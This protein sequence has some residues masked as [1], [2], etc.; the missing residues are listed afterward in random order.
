MKKTI[1]AIALVVLIVWGA[2]AQSNPKIEI[3]NYTGYDIKMVIFRC[4]I[5]RDTY[6]NLRELDPPRKNGESV[7][8]E[9][10]KSLREVSRYDDIEVEDVNNKRYTKSNVTVSANAR[11]EF[12]SSPPQKQTTATVQPQPPPPTPQ[13]NPTITIVNNTGEPIIAVSIRYAGSDWKRYT[14]ANNTTIANGQSFNLTLPN[15]LNT[16]NRYDIRLERPNGEIYTKN[17]V[18]V[19]ANA[20]VEFNTPSAPN[21]NE[22]LLPVAILNLKSTN[23]GRG[24][25]HPITVKDLK[26]RIE[27]LE[28][29]NGRKTTVVERRQILDALIND[30]IAFWV[31]EDH[32]KKIEPNKA[33]DWERLYLFEWR[34]WSENR[35]K[36]KVEDYSNA[37]AKIYGRQPTEDEL[38]AAVKDEMGLDMIEFRESIR[39]ELFIQGYIIS[40][41][42]SQISPV[43]NPTNDEI[44][45]CF[46]RN[47]SQFERPETVRISMIQVR[48]GSDVASK[49][50]AKDIADRII[51]E[52]GSSASKF[53]EAVTRGQA[54]NS[55]YD[56]GDLGYLPKTT[57]GEAAVGN[58][59]MNA[60]F[61]LREGE[62]SKV[63]EGKIGYQIIKITEKHMGKN[64]ELADIFQLGTKTT[65]RDYIGDYLLKERHQEAYTK[66]TQEL[67]VELRRVATIEIIESN[68]K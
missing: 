20:R 28:K 34:S 45:S 48:Y 67:I 44:L 46:N 61:S 15:P 40:R 66:A 11:F 59:F 7:T 23:G 37:L 10:P 4:T 62:V 36:M 29:R 6:V 39:K 8:L 55:S 63:I 51:R 43:R 35:I 18:T 1:M 9:L 16:V 64:L 58:A 3:V 65:V 32:V 53:D 49:A 21:T 17:N 38:S 25:T 26:Q 13:G 2:F 54:A 52:I 12:G 30:E 56:A 60:A 31:A 27:V 5:G 22:N 57:E 50:K 41:I 24:S 68:L 19:T 42:G 47:K 14:W 33:Q